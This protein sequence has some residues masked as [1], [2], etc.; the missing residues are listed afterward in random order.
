MREY[1]PVLPLIGQKKIALV[2]RSR[3]QLPKISGFL[4]SK[5]NL[6]IGVLAFAKETKT[7]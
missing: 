6:M 7:L 5:A 4:N 1:I 2:R 3:Q